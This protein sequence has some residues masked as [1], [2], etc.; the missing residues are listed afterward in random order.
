MENAF[1]SFD[2][3]ADPVHVVSWGPLLLLLAIV[4]VLSVSFAAGLVFLLIW[5]KRRKANSP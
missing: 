2:A 4:F 5:L 1:L 3:R